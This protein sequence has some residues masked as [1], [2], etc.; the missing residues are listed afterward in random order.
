MTCRQREMLQACIGQSRTALVWVTN[1]V[2]YRR[3]FHPLAKIP[4]PF[5]A[6]IT[7]FYIVKYNLFSGRSQFYLQV[8]KLHQQ[9]GPVISPDEIHLNDPGNYEKVYYIKSTAPSKAGYF[10]DA[11][12]LKTAAF[13]TTDNALHRVRRA[14][15]NPVFSRKAV[16][17]LEDVNKAKAQGLVRRMEDILSEGK[18]VDLHHGPRG[19]VLQA[20]PILGPISNLVTLGLAKRVNT[21]LYHFLQFRKDSPHVRFVKEIT[22]VKK[23]IDE[24]RDKSKHKT[25]F[26]QLLD[27]N[28]T[29]GHVVPGIEDLTDEAFN[30]LTAAADTTGHTMAILTFYAVSNTVIYRTLAAELKTAFPNRAENLD[31]ATLKKL[32]Y[33]TAVIMEG[34]RL[35]YGVPG[36]LPR[37]IAAPTAT[38]NGYTVPK[39]TIVGM[40]IYLMHRDPD[41]FPEPD[42]FDPERWLD[43]VRS[44]RLDKYL[45]PFSRGSSQCVGM[46]LAYL[47]LYV[48]IGTIFRKFENLRIF[49]TTREDLVFDDFFVPF[50]PNEQKK[51]KV[52]SET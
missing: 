37:T 30:I 32:P 12:G 31:Y 5:W 43:P 48:G 28:A 16:L 22:A 33:L 13:G 8:E 24:R 38:F 42:K 49:E 14:A 9:Y 10:Y 44:K 1:L 7:H 2:I 52:I 45:V 47:Q 26:R 39:G 41:I 36:R 4:G 46:H 6:S 50:F 40:S 29:E 20:F 25:I 11:F 27:P 17:Q 21:A 35:S 34:L 3:F 15:I 19:W 23:S 51:I 18:P